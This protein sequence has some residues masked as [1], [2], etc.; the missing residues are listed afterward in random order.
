MVK[1][2]TG[3]FGGSFDPVH[4]AHTALALAACEKVPLDEIF[5]IPAHQAPLK[6][7]QH[8]ASDADRLNMLKLALADFPAPFEILDIEMRSGS[9]VNYS[10]DTAR[11]LIEA[12][13]GRDFFW[14]IGSDHI[15]KL[16]D[17]KNIEDLAELVEFVVAER[18]GFDIDAPLAPRSVKLRKIPLSPMPHSST[19]LRSSLPNGKSADFMLD[20]RVKKYILEHKLYGCS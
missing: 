14:I 10:I 4:R 20:G 7:F 19:L 5:F 18:P 6:H 12:Y 8:V 13:P 2:R 9:P 1:K 11:K 17:W 15:G 3:I 16:K